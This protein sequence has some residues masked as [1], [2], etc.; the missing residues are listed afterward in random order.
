VIKAELGCLLLLLL[1]P[2]CTPEQNSQPAPASLADPWFEEISGPAKLDFVANS[3]FAGHYIYPEIMIGGGALFDMDADGDLDLYLVQAGDINAQGAELGAN[4]LFRNNGDLTFSDVT[5]GS[6]TADRAYGMGAGTGD[7]DNDGLTDLYLTNLGQNKLFHNNGDGTFTDV[8]ESS[9]TGSESWSFAAA[10]F[11]YDKD[12]D[13]DL[14]VVNYINWALSAELECYNAFG[15]HDYCHPNNYNAPATDTLY[16]NNG[17]GTF[18]DVSAAS[19]LQASHGNSLGMSIG[20]YDANGW[21][22][23]YVANDSMRNNLWLNQGDGRFIDEAFRRGC[24]LDEHGAAKSGMGVTSA[25]LDDDGD[26]DILV[27]NMV[28]QSDS[29]YRN[30]GGFFPIAPRSS[31]WAWP[32]GP[33]RA[34]AWALP[35]SITTDRWIC[36]RPT[37]TWSS[38]PNRCPRISSLSPIY[39][40]RGSG[41]VLKPSSPRP[42]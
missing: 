40:S 12:G 32:A 17:D 13:L 36:I 4:H 8:T 18:T 16:R 15:V 22:D 1:L 39:C 37:A 19:G 7:Y 38:R 24:A 3:G 21:L 10:F 30:E 27:G 31:A 9:G 11:D 23:V 28:T 5:A 2:A 29:Y 6:G 20:D 25:D 41:G 35:I 33:T 14:Y 26:L 42:V 34:M